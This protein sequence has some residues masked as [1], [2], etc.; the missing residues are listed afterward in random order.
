[1]NALEPDPHRQRPQLQRRLPGLLLLLVAVVL[2]TSSAAPIPAAGVGSSVAPSSPIDQPMQGLWRS[3]V[4]APELRPFAAPPTPWGA[5]H[6]GVDLRPLSVGATIRAPAD[7]RVSFAG[8]VVDRPVLSIDHGAGYL[9]S[10]EPV[11]AD[12]EVGDA[13]SVG[14]SVGTLAPG[15]G[16]C[17]APCLHWGVRLHGEYINPLLLTGDLEP[18][19]LLP[20]GKD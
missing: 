11:E 4:P 2:G 10:F 9:S 1:M 14:D 6:R 15:K 3:P 16:H 5:G 12:L 19:V 8:V 13:V 7:G 18:S 20:L 17:E